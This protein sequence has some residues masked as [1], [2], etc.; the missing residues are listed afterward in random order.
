MRTASGGPNSIRG[1]GIG[2]RWGWR[3]PRGVE[4]RWEGRG[5]VGRSGGCFRQRRTLVPGRR[6]PPEA[7][8]RG[9]L[10]RA[11]RG[12][13]VGGGGSCGT[14]RA[15]RRSE[16]GRTERRDGLSSGA[17]FLCSRKEGRKAGRV[18]TGRPRGA[19]LRSPDGTTAAPR[20]RLRP[21]LW[22]K[23]TD[24]R[25]SSE[26]DRAA[27]V[28]EAEEDGQEADSRPGPAGGRCWAREGEPRGGRD[29]GKLRVRRR[30]P[31]PSRRAR[32]FAA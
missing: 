7:A 4:G 12:D 30:L 1:V 21:W 31:R 15:R 20:P 13:C 16:R 28:T 29:R 2:A 9:R 25:A 3:P 5:G 19:Y 14:R 8:V 32:L 11:H 17:V 10:C 22:E 6:D 27:F 18:E 26:V 23:E 24:S